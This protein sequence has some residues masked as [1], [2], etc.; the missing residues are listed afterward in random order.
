MLRKC[1]EVPIETPQKGSNFFKR[2]NANSNE[3]KSPPAEHEIQTNLNGLVYNL[4][5]VSHVGARFSPIPDVH[6]YIP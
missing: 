6:Q 5:L 3:V 2:L 1:N 4:Y